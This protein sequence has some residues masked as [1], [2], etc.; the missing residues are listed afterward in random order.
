MY[1]V[2]ELILKVLWLLQNYRRNFAFYAHILDDE[3]LESS[4][5]SINRE[6]ESV[7]ILH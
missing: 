7:F 2:K 3:R 4:L 1:I 5:W 6:N